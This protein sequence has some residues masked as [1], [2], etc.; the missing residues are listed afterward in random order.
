MIQTLHLGAWTTKEN[1]T[2]IEKE[3]REVFQKATQ[4]FCGCGFELLLQLGTQIVAGVNYAFI[5]RTTSVTQKPQIGYSLVICHENTNKQ[6]S[7][8]KIQEIV[9]E[10]GEFTAG[11]IHCVEAS[12]ALITQLNS[13]EA[14]E[15]LQVFNAAFKNLQ[16]ALYTPEL[17]I[18]TQ[19]TRGINYHLIA[20]VELSN[21]ERTKGFRYVVVNHFMNESKIVKI[22]HL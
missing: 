21:Q 8:L 11:G 1:P 18:A 19:V 16:G 3:A 20:K 9:K 13:I 7:I 5:C 4:S 22:E 15:I 10:S 17:L 12:K 6:C 2:E 14:N